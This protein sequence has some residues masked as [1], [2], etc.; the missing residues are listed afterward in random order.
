MDDGCGEV[1]YGAKA[2]IYFVGPH[3]DAFELLELAEKV[4]DQVPP[5]IHF[6]LQGV[7]ALSALA[8][9]KCPL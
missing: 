7:A 1:D 5:L 4:L 3:R 9:G 6:P 8:V 2:F